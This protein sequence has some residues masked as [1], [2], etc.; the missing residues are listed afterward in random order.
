MAK[1]EK[2]QGRVGTIIGIVLC[3]LLVPILVI[4]V[5][6]IIK[7]LVNPNKVPSVPADR[8]DAFDGREA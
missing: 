7:G 4:N 8:S 1:K 5:T 6:I 2:K 3:L